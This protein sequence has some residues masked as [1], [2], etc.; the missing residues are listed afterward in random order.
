MAV[1]M[2]V[3]SAQASAFRAA[4]E[5]KASLGSS[6]A[7]EVNIFKNFCVQ[8]SS[9]HECLLYYCSIFGMSEQTFKG[10]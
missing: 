9:V 3:G 8:E 2:K 5:S 1:E 6:N 10:H 7:T 4:S